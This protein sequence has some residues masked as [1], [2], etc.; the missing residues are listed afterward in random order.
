M[1]FCFNLFVCLLL[2]LLL[3]LSLYLFIV[4]LLKPGQ[5]PPF[6]M[7]SKILIA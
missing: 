1:L 4:S 7:P 2:L 5:P 6:L 3:L